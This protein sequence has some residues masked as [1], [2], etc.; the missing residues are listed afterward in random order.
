MA[1]ETPAFTLEGF[2]HTLVREGQILW[3]KHPHEIA[4][5]IELVERGWAIAP[6]PEYAI[7]LVVMY[8]RVNR[9][10]DT[11]KVLRLAVRIFPDDQDIRCYASTTLFRHGSF[12]DLKEYASSILRRDEGDMFSRFVLEVGEFFAAQVQALVKHV[13]Q[14]ARGARPFFL[15]VAIWGEDYIDEFLRY[16]CAALLAPNNLPGLSSAYA[17]DLVIFTTPE[18]QARLENSPIFSRLLEFAKVSFHIYP[19]SMMI[20]R[21]SFDGHY[22]SRLGEYYAR[23]TKFALMSAAHY[24]ALE[25]GREVDA[26]VTA[27][28]ADNIFSDSALTRM[29]EKIAGGCDVVLVSGFRVHK[30][31]AA[32]G[33]EARH[34]K[35]DGSLCLSS[36]DYVDLLIDN[37]PPEYFVDSPTFADFP[38]MLCWRIP[39]EGVLVHANHYHPYCVAAGRLVRKLEPTIDPIDG[40]FVS[41]HLPAARLHLVQDASIAVSDWGD[42]PVLEQVATD[43]RRFSA[44]DVGLWLCGF[45]DGVR[46]PLFRSPVRL[47]RGTGSRR[48]EEAE[49]AAAETIDEIVGVASEHA[50]AATAWGLDAP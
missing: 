20:E 19:G 23:S 30:A 10:A 7:Q 16:A 14:S 45:W 46:A 41:R 50:R 38:L 27:M 31:K 48:W 40:R 3:S 1:P 26:L 9:H 8:D 47:R 24:V 21:R 17:V 37:I 33:A 28:G 42:V 25:A 13:R 39:E 44:R 15:T 22:G 2:A 4:K 49:V 32:L 34:R 5:A 12:E 11:L 35:D 18:G 6:S 29:A 43:E 36:E